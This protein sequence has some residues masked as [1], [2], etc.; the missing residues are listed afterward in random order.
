MKRVI[1]S[2]ID[3]PSLP[4]KNFN[5]QSKSFEH[6][7]ELC[8]EYRRIVKRYDG[9][10]YLPLDP[11]EYR[12]VY[13]PSVKNSWPE[14]LTY[15]EYDIG[16]QIIDGYVE[17]LDQLNIFEETDARNGVGVAYLYKDGS[18]DTPMCEIEI[19]EQEE[20]LNDMYF[21]SSSKRDYINKCKSWIRQICRRR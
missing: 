11:E 2:S 16:D 8:E 7:V 13:T 18:Y 1:R 20:I 10:S 12:S 5:K 3:I 17:A 14:E 6:F 15:E 19:D 9:E 4:L 21:S